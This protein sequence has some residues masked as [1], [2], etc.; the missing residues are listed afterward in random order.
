MFVVVVVV[1]VVV[2][3]EV[4]CWCLFFWYCGGSGDVAERDGVGHFDGNA[5]GKGADLLMNLHEECV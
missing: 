5:G 4:V 3:F 1:V 2:V